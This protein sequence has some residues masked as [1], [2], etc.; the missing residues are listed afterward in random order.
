MVKKYLTEI[1]E[2]CENMPRC[3]EDYL[4]LGRNICANLSFRDYLYFTYGFQLKHDYENYF[5]STK[6]SKEEPICSNSLRKEE[7]D[8]TKGEYSSKPSTCSRLKSLFGFPS[9]GASKYG[10]MST[11]KDEKVTIFLEDNRNEVDKDIQEMK[12]KSPQVGCIREEVEEESTSSFLVG[13]L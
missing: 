6:L 13:D 7:E 3:Y 10:D 4:D 8:R 12:C 11:T 1:I 2:A 5:K 9:K